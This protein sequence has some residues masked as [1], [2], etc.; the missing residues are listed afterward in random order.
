[1]ESDKIVEHGSESIAQVLEPPVEISLVD[2]VF[3]GKPRNTPKGTWVFEGGIKILSIYQIYD[4]KK[5]TNEAKY[6]DSHQKRLLIFWVLHIIYKHTNFIFFPKVDYIQEC[7]YQRELITEGNY[8][9]WIWL[10][11]IWVGL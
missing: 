4:Y 3:T 5:Q 7:L 6:Q 9:F 1:M 10:T 2:A 8:M 11:Y